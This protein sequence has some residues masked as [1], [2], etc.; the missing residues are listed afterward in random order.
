MSTPADVGQRCKKGWAPLSTPY[1]GPWVFWY[2][3]IKIE[4]IESIFDLDAHAILVLRFSARPQVPQQRVRNYIQLYIP[5][6]NVNTKCMSVGG[7]QLVAKC[8]NPNMCLDRVKWGEN[9][10][11]ARNLPVCVLDHIRY[12]F[13]PNSF[14]IL[15]LINLGDVTHTSYIDW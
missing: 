15:P 10:L 14:F 9:I 12:A 3:L 11:I 4:R 2:L 5:I 13:S 1:P 8:Q 6:S 7:S